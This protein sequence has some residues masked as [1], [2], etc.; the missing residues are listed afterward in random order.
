[1]YANFCFGILFKYFAADGM[2]K[3]QPTLAAHLRV[4]SL[5]VC[6][7]EQDEFLSTICLIKSSPNL[8]KIF[9]WVNNA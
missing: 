4:L 1:M 6:F 5:H 2:P 3:K 8:K 9:L 7:M